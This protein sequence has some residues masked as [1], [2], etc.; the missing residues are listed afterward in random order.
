MGTTLAALCHDFSQDFPPSGDLPSFGEPK[1]FAPSPPKSRPQLERTFTPAM[2]ELVAEEM[3]RL[4]IAKPGLDAK[5]RKR[6]A[7][8]LVLDAS[9]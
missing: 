3:A 5:A 9:L 2:R 4:A 7:R 1:R 8:A 6:R